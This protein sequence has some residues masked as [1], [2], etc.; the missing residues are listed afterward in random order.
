MAIIGINQVQVR[1][2]KDVMDKIAQGLGIANSLL[3]VSLAVPEY[4]QKRETNKL[5]QAKDKIDIAQNSDVAKPGD[6]NVISVP[7]MGDR[8][9]KPSLQNQIQGMALQE[10]QNE[11]VVP[12]DDEYEAFIKVSPGSDPAVLKKLYPTRGALK[13]AYNRV[14]GATTVKVED[15]SQARKFEYEKNQDTEKKTREKEERFIPSLN[16][17]ALT[18]AD[19]KDA[20]EAIATK[21]SI[22]NSLSELTKL[23]EKYQGGTV[24]PRNSEDQARAQQLSTK[25]LLKYKKLETLGVL[26][27]T[28][29]ELIDNLVPKNPLEINPSGLVGQDPTMA[30]LR[31]LSNFID[32]DFNIFLEARGLKF[33][34]SSNKPSVTSHEVDNF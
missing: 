29:M 11:A 5:A 24:D 21:N 15:P 8:I 32:D 1:E 34:P 22:Q 3:G 19:A 2:K 10:K 28:D 27:K 16:Q 6:S 17:Y 4:L 20:K 7:G 14:L 9:V 13:D 18:S 30:K 12:G 31:S 26:S 33:A 23:R 25:L